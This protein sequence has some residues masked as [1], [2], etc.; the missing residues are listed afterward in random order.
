[1][2]VPHLRRATF[3]M[4]GFERL[5]G[6]MHASCVVVLARAREFGLM[7]RLLCAHRLLP[8]R[9]LSLYS[10]FLVPLSQ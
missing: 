1:M 6:M 3:N 10:C 8:R 7:G 4:V 5:G 9:I 2:F